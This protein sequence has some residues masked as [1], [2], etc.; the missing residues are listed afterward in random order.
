MIMKLDR[1]VSGENREKLLVSYIS[2]AL[3][4]LDRNT[5]KGYYIPGLG[6][7]L[8]IADTVK[9]GMELMKN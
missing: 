2:N 4:Y 3:V 7:G 9:A 8:I 5:V 6:E 1:E